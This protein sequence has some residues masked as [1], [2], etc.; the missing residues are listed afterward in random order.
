MDIRKLLGCRI[1]ELRKS[2]NIT[3]EHLAELVNIDTVSLSNIERGKY[4][5]TAENLNKILAVLDVEPAELFNFQHLASHK[6]LL[7]EMISVMEN[8]ENLTRLM[9]KFFKLVK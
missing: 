8:D 9:Y 3:Q 7:E 2:K 4:Y 1:K 5:P 6:E